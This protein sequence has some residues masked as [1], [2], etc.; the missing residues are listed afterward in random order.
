[1]TLAVGRS[2]SLWNDVFQWT[3]H[4]ISNF[5]QTAEDHDATLPPLH[6]LPVPGHVGA[7]TFIQS[8]EHLPVGSCMQELVG[9]LRKTWGGWGHMGGLVKKLAAGGML[10]GVDF[11]C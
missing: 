11:H 7:A 5:S 10:L 1:M 8:D 6:G 9:H 2:H 3:L 4:P